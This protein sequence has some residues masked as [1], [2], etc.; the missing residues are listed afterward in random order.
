MKQS[1]RII[2]GVFG[3]VHY[4]LFATATLVSEVEASIRHKHY[5]R[6]RAEILQGRLDASTTKYNNHKKAVERLLTRTKKV[7]K[8]QTN[9]A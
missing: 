8:V 4:G 2:S 6:N 3:T 9:N 5:G 7:K 1:E